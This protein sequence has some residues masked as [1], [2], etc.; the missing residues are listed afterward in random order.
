MEIIELQ[1][2]H[3]GK[4]ENQTLR[5][6][7]GVNVLYGENEMGKTTLHAFIRAI[8]FGM[9]R[10]RGKA[11]KNNEYVLREPW[12]NPSYYAG[13]I[14]FESGDKLY[15]LTRNFSENEQSVEL[16]CETDGVELPSDQERIQ[17]LLDGFNEA[18][19]C[20]TVFVGQRTSE[21]AAEL[22][23]EI[24][25]FVTNYQEEGNGQLNVK[26]A[27]TQL[28][29]KRQDLE[30]KRKQDSDEKKEKIQ[31]AKAKTKEVER[32]LADLRALAEEQG[33][34][35]VQ[36][37]NRR[38]QFMQECR[39]NRE[40]FKKN[41][42]L[43]IAAF[44]LQVIAAVAVVVIWQLDLSPWLF[45]MVAAI[46]LIV[47]LIILL[48]I[49]A[50]KQRAERKIQARFHKDEQI[51]KK[52]ELEEEKLNGKQ[53]ILQE[54]IREK[55]MQLENCREILEE[56]KEQ[57]NQ[58]QKI[59]QKI[60]GL[61]IAENTIRDLSSEMYQEFSQKL[62]D[63][64]SDILSMI[65]RGRYTKVFLDERLNIRIDAGDHLL[66]LYQVSRGTMDQIYFALRM[67]V[68]EFFF[69]EE[70]LPVILDDVFVMYDE[71][72]LKETLRWLYHSD[73][74]VLLFTCHKRERELL[75]EIMKEEA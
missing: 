10:E 22:A 18:A 72:R 27:I 33:N 19:F 44:L 23:D 41:T 9:E 15:R 66:Y 42:S 49:Q 64:V 34:Q 29:E 38:S 16:F 54:E 3:F 59:D 71:R 24:R 62:N 40:D 32:E 74:Q 73:R 50:K 75:Q 26:Q 61:Q 46:D 51:L 36:K 58:P 20:N 28:K 8:L 1:I 65:T 68:G 4:F 31:K 25:N 47:L 52:M 7:G 2:K 57:E 60:E 39:E 63:T 35:L 69:Q 17:E 21:T 11:S 6:H 13:S 48:Q 37:R 53:E 67:A 56:E 70:K 30:R 43:W 14:R 45:A 5:F 12:N 55:M